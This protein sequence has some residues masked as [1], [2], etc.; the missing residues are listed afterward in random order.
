MLF[1]LAMIAGGLT[2]ALFGLPDRHSALRLRGDYLAIIT[3]GL[4]E[5]I[6]VLINTAFEP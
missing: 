3:T 4:R 2:A 6:R 1:P 5:I